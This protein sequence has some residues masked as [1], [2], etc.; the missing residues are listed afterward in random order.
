MENIKIRYYIE[1][2]SFNKNK[3]YGSILLKNNNL[4]Q[5]FFKNFD[6]GICKNLLED[7][8]RKYN[9]YLFEMLLLSNEINLNNKLSIYMQ[10]KGTFTSPD[11]QF[12][13][14]RHQIKLKAYFLKDAK[15]I[16]TKLYRKIIKSCCYRRKYYEK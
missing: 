6:N 4:E 16:I 8:I 10:L 3:Y 15:P 2:N 1:K 5:S 9:D 7:I 13:S 14:N 11:D 12:D